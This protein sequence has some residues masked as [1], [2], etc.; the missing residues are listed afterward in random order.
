VKAAALFLKRR[1]RYLLGA[2]VVL[3]AFSWW[4]AVRGL[5]LAAEAIAQRIP[6]GTEAVIGVEA[7]LAIDNQFCKGSRLNSRAQ[8]ALQRDF[9]KLSTGL[10]DG[11]SYELHLRDCPAIGPNAF[12]LP[13]G[14]IVLT[15]QLVRLTT[16]FPELSAML[17]HE[18]GHARLRHGLRTVLQSAGLTMPL[19]ALGGSPA[20]ISSLAF[21]V[22]TV[23]LQDGYPREFEDE[24]DGFALERLKAL[25]VSPRAF[26]DA[27]SRVDRRGPSKEQET[28]REYSSTHPWI[29]A[30][31]KR[32]L[33][34]ETDAERCAYPTGA[35]EEIIDACSR[36]IGSRKLAGPELAQANNILAW[37]LATSPQDGLRDGA[38]ATRLAFAACELTEWRN[39][40]YIDTLA[41]AHAETKNFA[42]AV[43]WQAKALELPD[44]QGTVR[45]E[46]QSRLALFESGRPYREPPNR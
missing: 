13:G 1:W 24:A 37:I 22:P 27:L 32:V 30:R 46:A 2:L 12:A 17:A 34:S 38:R 11:Q 36:A 23:V 42:E 39:A 44:F 16:R 33:E 35:T 45:A 14:A 6:A 21:A 10:A 43:R 28:A 3:A 19:A 5:P 7:L 8:E 4:A 41:A 26:A 40:A 9:R 29:A 15:D 31:I 18:V 25:G 20:A